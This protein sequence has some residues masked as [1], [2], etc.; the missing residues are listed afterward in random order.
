MFPA[1]IIL[2]VVAALGVA[3]RSVPPPPIDP[4]LAACIPD[5]AT[6]L[7]GVHLDRV[8]NSPLRQQ[9]PPT[10]AAFLESLGATR[11]ALIASDGARYL[12]LAHG[13]FRV[14]PAGST[15]L[16][17]GLAAAGSPDWLHAATV[18]QAAGRNWLL[19]HAEN[20]AG[21]DIWMAAAGN[22]HLPVTGNGENLNG[23]LHATQYTTLTVGLSDPVTLELVANCSGDE[24]ARHLEESVRALANI[25]A[26]VTARQPELSGLLRRIRVTREGSAVHVT[27]AVPAEELPAVLKM[28][29]AG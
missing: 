25:G 19:P 1:R 28:F 12:V 9:F 23:L 4:T 3:C 22:A 14:A 21:A 24:P 18:R 13:D 10:A 8:R 11:S 20:I 6:I 15:L 29:G 27:L 2:I 16:A 7:A 26:G 17:R 5:S